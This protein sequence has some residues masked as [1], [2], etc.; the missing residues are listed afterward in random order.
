MTGEEM[1]DVMKIGSR[2]VR[3]T[4]WKWDAQVSGGAM[5]HY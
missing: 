2:V 4:D 3:G 5:A 1:V